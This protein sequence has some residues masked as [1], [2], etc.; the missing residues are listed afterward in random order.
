MEL[1]TVLFNLLVILTIVRAILQKDLSDSDWFSLPGS[2]YFDSAD[3]RLNNKQ[4]QSCLDNCF[5]KDK[6]RADQNATPGLFIL[7]LSRC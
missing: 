2:F 1:N 7:S 5:L 4:K 3:R 6:Q